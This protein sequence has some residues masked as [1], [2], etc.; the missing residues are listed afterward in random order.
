MFDIQ[1]DNMAE[2]N[3]EQGKDILQYNDDMD[4]MVS[5]HLKLIQSS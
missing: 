3:L 5:P 2:F 4:E 1:Q